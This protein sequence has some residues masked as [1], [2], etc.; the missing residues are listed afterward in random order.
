MILLV[1]CTFPDKQTAELISTAMVN[2]K[3]AACYNLF[4][5]QSGYIWE[6]AFCQ[7]SECVS[8]MKTL[9][10]L[11]ETIEKALLANH[12]YSTPCVL[13]WQV[14]ANGAYEAYIKSCVIEVGLSDFV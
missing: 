14:A 6:G 13:Q 10:P 11:G 1:Y 3:L 5:M 9:P 8:I 2:Q 4:D 12:P 7:E